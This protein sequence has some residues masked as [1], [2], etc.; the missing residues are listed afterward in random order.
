MCRN[1]GKWMVELDRWV[2]RLSGAE[3]ETI[4]RKA[5]DS[6]LTDKTPINDWV[7]FQNYREV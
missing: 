7:N 5:T 1:S 6:F 4:V 3:Q 2:A